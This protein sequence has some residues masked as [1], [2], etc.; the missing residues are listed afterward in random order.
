MEKKWFMK[1]C[2]N[3]R[4]QLFSIIILCVTL[5]PQKGYSQE[6]K[7]KATFTLNFIKNIGWTPE[8]REGDFR[9]G[10]VGKEALSAELR[11]QT[12]GKKFGNQNIVIIDFSK[13]NKITPCQVI[14]VGKDAMF[15][16]FSEKIISNSGGK[17]FLL[18]TEC[19]GS[20]QKGATV[21]FYMENNDLKFEFS[22][23]N[24]LKYE[25]Q[26]NSRIAQLASP[27]EA[28]TTDM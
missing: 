21:N 10:V 11:D 19:P 12:M 9:I 6:L 13:S 4:T 23:D 24:A 22:P 26:Y 1:R 20:L 2:A 18:I 17:K 3:T 27:Q 15:E 5:L 14:F 7:H 25:L 8:Q 28:K 16:L